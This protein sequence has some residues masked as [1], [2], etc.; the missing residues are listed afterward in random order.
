MGYRFIDLEMGERRASLVLNRPPLNVLNIEMLKE[1]NEAIEEASMHGAKVLLI[2]GEGKA[3]SAGV[4]VADHT[5]DRVESM[6]HTFHRGLLRLL[7]FGGA[8]VAQVHGHC[9]GGGLELAMACDLVYASSDAI[10]GQPEIKL[11][12]FPPFGAAVYPALLG[13]RRAADLILTG[14]NVTAEE[15]V[16]MGMVNAVFPPDELASRVQAVCEDL[17]GYSAVALR[18][19]KRAMQESF[20]VSPKEAL[21]AVTEVYLEELMATKDATEGLKAFMEKRKPVWGDR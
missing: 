13:S 4:D 8:A 17:E 9:L 15:A 5:K 7:T 6:L 19:A 20:P 18:L 10:L 2:G 3:F 21:D 14:R 1:F 11:A 16:E 12:S